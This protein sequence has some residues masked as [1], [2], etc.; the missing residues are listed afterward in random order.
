VA[1]INWVY[2]IVPVNKKQGTI[3][4][5]VDFRD[6][7][8]ACPKDNYPTPF[9]DQIV[10]NCAMREIFS[11][12]DNFY[13][14]NQINILCT[15]QHKTTFICPWGTFSY[16]KLLFG[17]KNVGATFQQAMSYIFHDIKNIV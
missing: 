17:I 11:L 5:C 10:D 4:V 1:L 6:I 13:G 8:K 15:D 3:R 14:Y 2:N 12:M 9:I 16:Q 7:K